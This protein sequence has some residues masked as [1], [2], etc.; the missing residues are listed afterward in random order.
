M[1]VQYYADSLGLSRPDHVRLNERYIYLFEQWLR[2]NSD[3]EVFLINRARGA[4][5]IDKLYQLYKEDLGYI[6]GKKDIL[7][8]HEGVCD[9][10]PRPIPLWLRG[11]I[12]RMPVFVRSRVIALLHK[13][14]SKL[15]KNGFVHYLVDKKKYE[16]ILREWLTNA[17]SEFDR[18]Y[19]FNIAPTIDHIEAHS[20]GFS[21][22]IL[23]YN[24]IIHKV[25]S[26]LNS[27][28]VFLI[29][30]HSILLNDQGGLQALIT[31]DDGH[32]ITARAHD[33]YAAQLIALEKQF[34]K[35][36]A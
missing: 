23:E 6:T 20:P 19:I 3:E 27:R 29:D 22:S 31:T 36:S 4:Q 18:I 1:I 9:C 25:I 26:E 13:N 21:K 10:A 32:H 35:I 16:A 15:L 7:I 28:K 17:I 14:R 12:S 5:T 34:V 2:R 24:A 8:I 30:V 33:I 11:I